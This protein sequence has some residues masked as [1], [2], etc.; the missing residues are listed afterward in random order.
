MDTTPHATD[1][2]QTTVKSKKRRKA[3]WRRWHH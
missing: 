1:M 2:P 3:R